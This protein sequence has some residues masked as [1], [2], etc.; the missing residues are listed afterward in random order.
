M[1]KFSI[2]N[3]IS[4]RGWLVLVTLS[5]GVYL[6]LPDRGLAQNNQGQNDQGIK[7]GVLNGTYSV[8]ITGY[9]PDSSGNKVPLAVAGRVTHFANGTES[10]VATASV[11]GQLQTTTFTG[12][13]TLNP[14]GVSWSETVT[15]TSPPFL[16]L[17]YI[18]YP[19]PD[20]NTINEVETDPE[21]TDAGV[22]TRGR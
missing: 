13:L 22:L 2:A 9:V 7:L 14:D 10:G 4:A 8:H 21:T 3:S 18:L 11:N 19:T 1:I 16:T 15:Q 6:L 12:T 20:G 5:M 17:H